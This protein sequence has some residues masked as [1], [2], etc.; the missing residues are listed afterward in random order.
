MGLKEFILRRESNT[1][2][3]EMMSSGYK[4]A[5]EAYDMEKKMREGITNIRTREFSFNGVLKEIREH[6]VVLA[7]P[8]ELPEEV[9]R[10]PMH[11]R[12]PYVKDEIE[13]AKEFIVTCSPPLPLS[14]VWM[15]ES[16][17]KEEE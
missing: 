4:A 17:E 13:I 16:E 10:V 1:S 2:K 15:L 11:A 14:K 9:K 5:L 7:P 6:S 8:T 12:I 3:K